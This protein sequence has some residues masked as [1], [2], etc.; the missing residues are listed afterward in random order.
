MLC[1]TIWEALLWMDRAFESN[2]Q[3]LLAVFSKAVYICFPVMNIHVNLNLLS[4]SF[5]TLA[6]AKFKCVSMKS[7]QDDTNLYSDLTPAQTTTTPT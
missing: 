3:F 1:T 6:Y 4:S 7:H 2:R 5:L